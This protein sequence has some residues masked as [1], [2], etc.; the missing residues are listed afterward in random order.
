MAARQRKRAHA[1]A[2]MG[3]QQ[4]HDHDGHRDHA[5]DQLREVKKAAGDRVQRLGRPGRGL[6]VRAAV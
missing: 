4:H 5:I 6:D 1:A 3:Q 2:V